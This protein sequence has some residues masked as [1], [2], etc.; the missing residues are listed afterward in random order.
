MPGSL[1]DWEHLWVNKSG[2][3]TFD[4]TRIDWTNIRDNIGDETLLDQVF[5]Y[6]SEKRELRDSFDEFID[7]VFTG[8]KIPGG[9]IYVKIKR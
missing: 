2:P 9:T 8:N 7:G 1:R 6:D 4:G 5:F 3:Y